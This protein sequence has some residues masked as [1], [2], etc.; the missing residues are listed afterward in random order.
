MYFP[1]NI[2]FLQVVAIDGQL[3]ISETHDIYFGTKGLLLIRER[4][5]V[6]VEQLV[7]FPSKEKCYDTAN[8]GAPYSA[9]CADL[10]PTLAASI[11]NSFENA[12]FTVSNNFIIEIWIQTNSMG[13]EFKEPPNCA[14]KTTKTTDSKKPEAPIVKDLL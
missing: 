9:V 7:C 11:A 5:G 10:H 14:S 8:M 13:N 12:R 4:L 2:L 3:V 6:V 1:N